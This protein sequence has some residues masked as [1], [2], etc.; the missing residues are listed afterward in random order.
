MKQD[1]KSCLLLLLFLFF[2][3]ATGAGAQDHP[4]DI[5]GAAQTKVGI[6]IEDLRT[7]EV[8]ADING[9]DFFVPASVMKSVTSATALLTF[10]PDGRFLTSVVAVGNISDGVLHGNVVVN[11]IGD[12]TVESGH[13]SDTKGFP[14]KIVK[15]LRSLGVDTIKGVVIIDES[16]FTDDTAPEGWSPGDLDAY[17]GTLVHGANYQGNASGKSAVKNPAARMMR[18]IVSAIGEG[19]IVLENNEDAVVGNEETLVYL[20][21]SPR[22]Y[23]ILHSLMIRSDNM[24]AEAILRSMAEGETRKAAIDYEMG[25]WKER[26]LDMS[27]IKIFDGSGLSRMDRLSPKW[28]ASLY[29]W[30][31]GSEMGREYSDLFP[32]A[33]REGTM[34]SFLKGTR[35]EGRL[36]AKTGSM[37]GI[38]GY[39]GYLL[40]K[41]GNATHSVVIFVNDF[42]CERSRL[43]SELERFLLETLP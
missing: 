10:Y 20:N 14:G 41:N 31:N 36:A 34:R 25:M 28:V 37:R 32:R 29:R 3:V 17:Y 40:D 13:F 5:P 19:G 43:R 16:R 26:G 11:A 24:F 8:L 4:L 22:L 1:N 18:H 12:P 21:Q 39:G 38:Q 7:G 9:E 2:T 30:M 23:D 35:L 42:N 27:G 33:G 15:G 6:Y